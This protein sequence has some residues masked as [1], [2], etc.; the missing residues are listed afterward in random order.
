MCGEKCT[1]DQRISEYSFN[2]HV[3]EKIDQTITIEYPWIPFNIYF[4]WKSFQK[5][6]SATFI[7]AI[8]VFTV[9]IFT[10]LKMSYIKVSNT[11]PYTG[12]DAKY[13]NL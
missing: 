7:S 4:I 10:D 1:P 13:S 8:L 11:T 12:Y 6:I 3:L 5:T 9:N 2:D